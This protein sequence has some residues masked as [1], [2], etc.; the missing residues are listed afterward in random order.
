MLIRMARN[1]R[2]TSQS[3]VIKNEQTFTENSLLEEKNPFAYNLEALLNIPPSRSR[4]QSSERDS[5]VGSITL[6]SIPI[7]ERTYLI[8]GSI[9]FFTALTT[10]TEDNTVPFVLTLP[11]A[12]FPENG[13]VAL[14]N[15]AWR[16]C[17]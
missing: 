9:I 10:S 3:A 6:L 2:I 15:H 13:I 17:D 5:N 16:G 1:H 4:K 8:K 7:P 14:L 11:S 12:T